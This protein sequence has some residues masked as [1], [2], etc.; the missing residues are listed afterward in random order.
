MASIILLGPISL[1]TCL[2]QGKTNYLDD[3]HPT[4]KDVIELMPTRI[5]LVSFSVN[6][7]E[8]MPTRIEQI[9]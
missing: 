5:D 4:T 2:V 8:L 3:D 6:V 7:I 1:K 9:A